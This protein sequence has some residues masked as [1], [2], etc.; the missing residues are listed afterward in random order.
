MSRRACAAGQHA[1]RGAGFEPERFHALDHRADLV[2]V[3]VLRL[4]PGRA[5]AEAAGAGLLGRA[6]LG[7][8][9]VELMSFSASTPVS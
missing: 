3:A 6:R 7:E 5:H 9:G 8:H 4:A 1:E 2:E